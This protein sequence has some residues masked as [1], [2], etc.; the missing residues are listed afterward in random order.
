[1]RFNGATSAKWPE[2][3]RDAD[4]FGLSVNRVARIRDIGHGGQ[5]LLS[6]AAYE[7][8]CQS[9]PDGMTF[10]SLDAWRLKGMPRPE[11]VYQVEVPGLPR[12]F[13]PLRAVSEG[14]GN[15]PESLASFVGREEA[16]AQVASRLERHR[17]V[18]LRG[19]GCCGK[20]RLAIASPTGSRTEEKR[21]QHGRRKTPHHQR[22]RNRRRDY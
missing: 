2:T 6:R 8:V 17:L 15:L 5:T 21:G 12:S 20:T 1:M 19:A 16:V 18:T 3:C 4:Y 7:I 22:G 11:T 10:R 14:I 13:P 9:A